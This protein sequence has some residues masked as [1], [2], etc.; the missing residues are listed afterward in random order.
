[1]LHYARDATKLSDGRIVV[2]NGGSDELRIFDRSGTHVGTWGG[3]GEGPGEFTALGPVER[4]ISAP[5]ESA[6]TNC[7][8]RSSVGSWSRIRGETG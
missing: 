2:A 3:Q 7:G 4:G 6:S 5:L 8:R 1:M